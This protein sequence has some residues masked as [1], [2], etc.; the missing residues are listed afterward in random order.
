MRNYSIERNARRHRRKAVLV[1]LLLNGLLLAALT[2]HGTI[3][4]TSILP[5]AVQEWL[6]QAAPAAPLP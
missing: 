2:Y 1:T 6:G 3:D 4:L 5:Q